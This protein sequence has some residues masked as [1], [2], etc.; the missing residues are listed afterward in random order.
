MAHAIDG[1]PGDVT[2]DVR[3]DYRRISIRSQDVHLLLRG[4]GAFT[5]RCPLQDG[6]PSCNESLRVTWD[7]IPPEGEALFRRLLLGGIPPR[8]QRIPMI[9]AGVVCHPGDLTRREEFCRH[10]KDVYSPSGPVSSCCKM[11]R[12]QIK[13]SLFFQ[14]TLAL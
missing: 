14:K 13:K 7:G 6:I 12:K 3:L 2:E 8:S 4:S 11:L 1:D 9:I 10:F 5:V